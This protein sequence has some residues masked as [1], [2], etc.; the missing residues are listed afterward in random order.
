MILSNKWMIEAERYNECV[1]AILWAGFGRISDN[2][3]IR[4]KSASKTEALNLEVE[5]V[6]P[7]LMACFTGIK[8][9]FIPDTTIR[10][11]IEHAWN[12]EKVKSRYDV[13]IDRYKELLDALL[14]STAI[15]VVQAFSIRSMLFHDFR[16]IRLIDPILPKELYPSKWNG[17]KAFYIAQRIYD[18]L[19]HP[20]E[21]YIMEVMQ[22]PEGR[23]PRAKAW[24]FDRFG[25]LTKA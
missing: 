20:S 1:N 12:L 6:I 3:F 16:R 18:S 21:Q 24:F 19:A 4:P 25:G 14:E 17:D 22:G 10:A 5:E 13:F 9:P 7:E 23:L 8:K 11:M 15:S 2:V